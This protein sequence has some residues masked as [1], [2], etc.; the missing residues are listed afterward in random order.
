MEEM[1]YTDDL[2][3]SHEAIFLSWRELTDILGHPHRGDGDDD[4]VIVNHLFATGVPYWVR[5]AEGWTEEGGWGIYN[6]EPL[7]EPDKE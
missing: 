1:I 2:T 3:G 4:A 7:P 6:P 5:H